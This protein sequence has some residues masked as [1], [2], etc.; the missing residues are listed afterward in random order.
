MCDGSGATAWTHDT[1]GRILQD[2]RTIGVVTGRYDNDSY[3]LDGSPANVYALGYT[4]GYA[5][6]GAERPLGVTN[7]SDPFN[8]ATRATY[9]PNGAVASLSLGYTPIAVTNA[10]NN[11]LQPILLSAEA[12]SSTIFSEC[13]DFHLGVVITE[14]SPCSFSASTAGDNGNV[15]TIVNNRDNTRSQYFTYDS[16]NRIASGESNGSQWGE[17]FT[18]D[19]WGNLTNRSGLVGKTY[20]EPLSASANTNN[21]LSGFGY[22]AAGN[23]ISNSPASYVYDGENRLVWTSGYRYVYDGDG[24]RVEKCAVVSATTPCPTSGTSGTLY[25][26]G[27]NS[28]PQAESD[29]SGNVLENYIFFNGQRIAR[30]DGSTKAVHFYFSDHLGSHAVVENATGTVCEQDIDYYPYGG[31]END[32]CPNVAQNYK[33][34]GKERD[35]ESGLD[36]FGKRYFGSSLGRFQTPD[37]LL[38]SGRPENPQTW[39]KYAYVLNNPLKLTDPTGLWEWAAN[40][41]ASDDKKCN[42]KYEQNQQKFRDA[43]KDLQKARDSYTKGSKEYNRLNA[44]LS[45]YGTENDGNN[46]KVGFGALAGS[47]AAE[48][49]PSADTH[50][51]LSFNVTFDPSKVGNAAPVDVGH[52]GTHI[53]DEQNPWYA[54]AGT[55]EPF[56]LEYRGYQTS[57]WV[58]EGLGAGTLTTG[59]AKNVIWNASWGAVDREVMRDR[60]ITNQVEDKDHPET[61]FHN[62]WPN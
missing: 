39:N 9:A 37:P 41:C 8:F 50:G 33:F 47:A 14:P 60:G 54:G 16:L 27:T 4:Y 18:I 7:T 35:S 34:T 6:T 12:N 15:Y 53:S 23:L 1:M 17:L 38:N 21:Q 2:R 42:K 22:D 44:S 25:W 19:A 5:Y 24:K 56:Q 62:P 20:Y 29:L 51:N 10:Y 48:T 52:E 43:L 49:T 46:V 36:N 55:L 57:S 28:E 40:T 3:N 45:A 13:F 31:Q 61:Q 58:A 59:P 26:Y 11:R 30:R 32:Y